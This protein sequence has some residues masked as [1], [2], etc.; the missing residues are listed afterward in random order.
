MDHKTKIQRF[1]FWPMMGVQM[2]AWLWLQ[3]NGG[4]LDGML[5]VWFCVGMMVGQA[6]ATAECIMTRAW[7][8]LVVQIYFFVFTGYGAIVRYTQLNP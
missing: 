1:V 4:S 8:T 6:G 5:Y 2:L 3:Y 7:G